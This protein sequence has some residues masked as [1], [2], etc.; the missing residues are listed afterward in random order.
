[1]ERAVPELPT[2]SS[3]CAPVREAVSARLD[4]ESGHLDPA[5]LEAHLDG[6]AACQ[7]FEAAL[8][9]INRRV[10][11]GA[12]DAVPDLTAPILVA[13]A[14]DR[15]AVGDRRI[16][17]L[18][19]VVGLAGVV[20]LILAVP[21]LL[22]LTGPLLHVGWDLG[23]FELAL[24]AGLLL[25]ALQPRRAAGVLPVA[26]VAAAVATVGGVVDV[27]G[28]QATVLTEMTHVT[29]LVGVVALWA[30]TRRLPETPVLTP[31]GAV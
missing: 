11:V 30:L 25:A 7:R 24:G 20:Q 26:A 18:R 9:R 3:S 27:I 5:A 29:E 22:V 28:G 2:P 1:M 17:D 14:E 13:L 19:V 6:C 4:G 15:A 10:T 8:P 23:A 31:A 12:A 16:H 21:V